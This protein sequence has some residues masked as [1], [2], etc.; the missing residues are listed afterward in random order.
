MSCSC[1]CICCVGVV[2]VELRR[3]GLVFACGI[4]LV[5]DVVD[6]VGVGVDCASVI[7]P[8]L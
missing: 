4:L 6:I 1:F 7:K 2:E 8:H 3:E 5:V